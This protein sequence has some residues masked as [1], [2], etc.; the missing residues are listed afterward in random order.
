MMNSQDT[1]LIK[2]FMTFSG[3]ILCGGVAMIILREQKTQIL[4]ESPK[5]MSS[6]KVK[7]AAEKVFKDFSKMIEYLRDK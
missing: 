7:T 4:K 6:S 2:P 5:I 3:I 1:I